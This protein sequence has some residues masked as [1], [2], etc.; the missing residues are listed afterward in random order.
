[1]DADNIIQLVGIAVTA[2]VAWW[3]LKT[4]F[5]NER[6]KRKEEDAEKVNSFVGAPG[7]K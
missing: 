4:T 6:K 7:Q 2:L 1:V 5:S 3:T